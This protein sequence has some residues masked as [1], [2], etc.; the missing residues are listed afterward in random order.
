MALA[1]VLTAPAA[2]AQEK[3]L[4]I[5][6]T[7]ADI[8]RTLGQPDQGFEGN[9][10]TGIPMY[11]G[12]TQWDLS[13]ADAP[14]VLIPA[15]A[16]SWAVDAK[17]KTKWVFKLRPGVKFHDGS[18]LNADAVVWNVGKVLDKTA[19]Q[20]DASQVG[21]TASRMPTL[22]SARKVDDLTVELT[23]SEPDSF[24]PI[25]LTNLYMVSPAKWQA[26]YDKATGADAKAKTAAAWDAFSKDASGTGPW[27]MTK[28]TPRERLE[29][30][31][32][33]AYW[34]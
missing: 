14:S 21:V 19:P 11:D 30:V 3:T 13:K 23:T 4:R 33:E 31:K 25:N 32:N 16:T 24:L 34:D 18:V 5:A 8:P 1:A 28:F 22:V 20:F 2:F 27:K 6:M 12:L 9:R 15:L 26:F 7:A 17:D 29:L 10:F